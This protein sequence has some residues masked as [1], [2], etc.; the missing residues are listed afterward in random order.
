MDDDQNDELNCVVERIEECCNDELDKVFQEADAKSKHTGNSMR[1]L[2]QSARC[3]KAEFLKDQQ[4]NSKGQIYNSICQH[5]YLF[6]RE[7]EAA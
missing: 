7:L 3:A 2:W 1:N 5:C 4:R 6:S